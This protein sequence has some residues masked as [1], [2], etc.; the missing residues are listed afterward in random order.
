MPAGGKEAGDGGGEELDAFADVG[1]GGTA[2]ADLLGGGGF[3]ALLAQGTP[4]GSRCCRVCSHMH[5]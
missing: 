4:S 2:V 3:P 5:V 1:V